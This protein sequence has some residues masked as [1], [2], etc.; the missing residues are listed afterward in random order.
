MILA[1]NGRPARQQLRVNSMQWAF[2]AARLANYR[3]YFYFPSLDPQS[4]MIPWTRLEVARKLNWAYNNIGYMQLAVRG[5]AQDEVDVGI[6]PRAVTSNPF[7]NRALTD[8]W[9]NEASDPRFF[10]EA[11]L[12][13]C[14]SQQI[15]IR[16]AIYLQHEMFGQLL[17]PTQGSQQATIHN[18]PMYQVDNKRDQNT[19]DAEPSGKF[20][21]WRDGVLISEFGRAIAYRVLLDPKG[22]R[23]I[24]VPA[25]DMLH[26]HD[27]FLPGQVRGMSP[28]SS[29]AKRFYSIDDIAR[30]ATS[31]ELLRQR[32]AYAITKG[33]ND[34]NEPT[35]IP[36]AEIVDTIET[37]NPDGTKAKT[38]IQR[39]RSTD[40][41]GEDLDIADLPPG[42]KIEM[43]EST[44]GGDAENWSNF[45]LREIAAAL[46]RPAEYLFNL[47]GI[48]QG[49][50]SRLV[51]KRVQRSKNIIRQNQL[52]PQYWKRIYPFKTWQW[53]LAGRF[54]SVQG[55]V[56]KDWFR[57]KF[58]C[59]PDDTVDVAR[60]LRIWADMANEGNISHDMLQ[61]ML[62]HYIEDTDF[63]QIHRRIIREKS[64]EDER[65]ALEDRTPDY[66]AIAQRIT[67]DEIFRQPA[68][69]TETK[70]LREQTTD[71]NNPEDNPAPPSPSNPKNRLNGHH[72][73][74]VR[75]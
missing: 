9:D 34:D 59:P 65:A 49:T 70:T 39:I 53:I 29:V 35:L 40:G 25:A 4:Q 13:N 66:S 73:A 3:G 12:E 52:I 54:D 27:R 42:R 46:D 23:T 2:E 26:F 75:I 10:D 62:G 8:L 48:T 64:I 50:L 21:S 31:G 74:N 63:E 55:G 14:Y 72:R 30:A 41:S 67:Y 56:P 60:E 11:G 24:D 1:P 45:L 51:M 61:E 5:C 16:V 18:I 7:F 68:R 6:W 44:K 38:H 19:G 57:V 28:L 37:E 36:G 58:I 15:G 20:P 32:L 69:T 43:V 22:S 47:A 17:R 71:I 33:P